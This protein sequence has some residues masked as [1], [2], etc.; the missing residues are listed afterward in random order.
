[1]LRHGILAPRTVAQT[2]KVSVLSINS[3]KAAA[4]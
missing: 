3:A 1:M 4:A 2:W